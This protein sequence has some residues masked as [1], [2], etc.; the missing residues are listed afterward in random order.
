MFIKKT[1]LMIFYALFAGA[2]ICIALIMSG[3]R[4]MP[5]GL[6]AAPDLGQML[7][8]CRSLDVMLQVLLIFAC[9]L[10]ILT[11]FAER[12]GS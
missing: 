12:K 5:L 11:F 3:V 6:G 1:S 10:G 4:I 7:W 8:G 9:A 2:F